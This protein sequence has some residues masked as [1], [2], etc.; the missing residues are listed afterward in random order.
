ML[1][2]RRFHLHKFYLWR[3][4]FIKMFFKFNINKILSVIV[5]VITLFI[6]RNVFAE[7]T[8]IVFTTDIQ[9]IGLGQNSGPI[10]IQLQDSAGNEQKA[11]ETIY[12][13]LTSSNTGELSSNKDSW[14]VFG[15]LS[16]DFST[17]SIYIS[18]GSANRTF[19]YKG[20]ISGEHTIT[21]AAKSKSGKTFDSISQILGIDINLSSGTTTDSV[22]TTTQSTNTSQTST[23]TNTQ[24]I[25]KTVVRYVSLHSNPEDLSDYAGTQKF[26]ISAGRERVG[27]V[28][29]PIRFSEKSNKGTTCSFSDYIWTYGDGTKD[30]GEIVSHNYKFPGEYN[31]LLNGKCGDINAVSRTK[32]K[33]LKP[34]ITFTLI[35]SGDLEFTNLGKTEINMGD[36]VI[37]TTLGEFV[38]PEDTIISAGNKMVLSKE[39]SKLFEAGNTIELFDPSKCLYLSVSNSD[40]KI[41]PISISKNTEPIVI[42]ISKIEVDNFVSNYNKEVAIPSAVV[43]IKMEN[44][45]NNFQKSQVATVSEAVPVSSVSSSTKG[46]WRNL[47]RGIKTAARVFYDVE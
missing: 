30:I 37:K 22:A 21:V 44:I 31:V 15:T 25:T 36:W 3:N 39:I 43:N 33:I 29:V 28:G 11:T 42:T 18:S 13:N 34:E 38:F 1:G 19:Y 40:T 14:K 24:I 17:S 20:L 47:F 46:F 32:V 27:Y 41:K 2:M 23:T 45:S 7:A 6:A 9:N 10:T 8:K 26:E 16:P 12:L 35:S 5:I 4:M